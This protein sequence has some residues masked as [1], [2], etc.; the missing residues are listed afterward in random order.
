MGRL[1]RA[2]TERLARKFWTAMRNG[3]SE[4]VVPGSGGIAM[5][6]DSL[7]HLARWDILFPGQPVCNFGIGGERSAHLLQRLEPLIRQRPDRIFIL[8]GT[9][10]LASGL[11][12][13]EIG[14]NV[15][16]ILRR[17]RTAL[18]ECRLHLQ[19]VMP[20]A[21][22]FAARIEALNV[23]YVELARRHGAI[24]IDLFPA[25]DDGSGQMQAGCT[26]DGLHLNGSG[27]VRWREQLMPHIGRVP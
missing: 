7:T 2:V 11:A 25:F 24:W 20:R 4:A 3:I 6:G 14:A 21:R 26:Y 16:E 18:P 12:P 10:D 9:N 23:V 22:K 8:I 13:A 15:D 19:G 27:Y 5:F 1:S 17:L